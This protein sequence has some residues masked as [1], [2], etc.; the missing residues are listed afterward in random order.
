MR[1]SETFW[2][3]PAIHLGG[4]TLAVLLGWNA[5]GCGLGYIDITPE[6]TM[7]LRVNNATQDTVEIRVTVSASIASTSDPNSDPG[8]ATEDVAPPSETDVLISGGSETVGTI[9]CGNVITVV[10]GA[11]GGLATTIVLSGAGTGTPGFDSGSVGANGERFLLR[12]THFACGDTVVVQVLSA[13][14]GQVVVVEPGEDVPSLDA[15]PAGPDSPDTTDSDDP[16]DSPGT[17]P[18]D[19]SAEVMLIVVNAVESTVQVNFATG[20]GTLASSGGVDVSSEIDVRVPP[21]AT[22]VGSGVCAEEYIIAAAHLEATGSTF[23]SGG[24]EI[25]ESG[26]NINFHGVS[27][28]GDG[29]GT[30]GFDGNSLAVS[31][32]RLFQRGIH[33]ECGDVI[34]VAITATN[35]QFRFDDEGMIVLDT[36]GNPTIQ[37]NVGFGQVTVTSGN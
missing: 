23:T 12:G 21:G 18:I 7:T 16:A 19:Q 1:S 14:S 24:T 15:L 9:P 33:F 17:V 2:E 27:L 26:G 3:R 30:E 34:T 31:R 8:S 36:F 32:G 20:S 37:Y 5:G 10:A 22:T 6:Q 11:P 4:L 25:F 13:N 29:T 35:N 28:T